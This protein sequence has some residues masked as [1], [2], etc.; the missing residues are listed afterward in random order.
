MN[1]FMKRKEEARKAGKNSFVYNN[2][3][4]YKMTMKTGMID[5]LQ[6]NLKQIKLLSINH[7]N[8]C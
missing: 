5:I 3:T 1:E 4:Y 2:K 7:I 8:K 6:I